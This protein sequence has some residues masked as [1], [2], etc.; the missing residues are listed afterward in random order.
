MVGYAFFFFW[1]SK[2]RRRRKK[3]KRPNI[4]LRKINRRFLVALVSVFMILM[5]LGCI[6]LLLIR[7]HNNNRID[8]H[9]YVNA[10]KPPILNK[11]YVEMASAFES[12]IKKFNVKSMCE[13][14]CGSC[15]WL[16]NLLDRMPILKYTG[17]ENIPIRVKQANA[18]LSKYKD[19]TVRV[20]KPLTVSPP[21]CDLVVCMN[22]LS[23]LSYD[24]I[25]SAMITLSKYDCQ[26][27][28]LG[29]F[30]H[31]TA[32]NR[33]IPRNGKKFRLNLEI[34]PFNM[35]PAYFVVVDNDSKLQCYV[36]TISQIR[37]FV[38]ANSFWTKNGDDLKAF[39]GDE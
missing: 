27:V 28:A 7:P 36:Y 1:V 33:N 12:I 5:S 4:T 32:D 22:Y 10:T 29:S 20:A 30:S 23:T 31:A 16:P 9:F 3:M 37:S 15:M 24:E 34:H 25:R 14:E 19:A 2:V 18:I 26:Y 13:I 21:K 11:G 8:E 39:S 35:S 17:Y 38:K 6:I